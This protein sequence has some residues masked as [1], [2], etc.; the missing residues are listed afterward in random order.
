M[1]DLAILWDLARAFAKIS[2]IAIG[3]VN[4]VLPAMRHEVV[5]VLHWMSDG[6]FM[7]LFAVTQ[8]TPGPNVVIV[9]LIGW[10]MA[11]LTGLL[12]ATI[13]MLLPAC[14]LAFIVG[15]LASRVSGSAGF[16][17]AQQA[18]VPVA[19]GLIVAGG[20]DL[21]QAAHHGWLTAL[22]TAGSAAA[23]IFTKAN[24]VWALLAS[25]GVALAANYLGLAALL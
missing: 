18:L 1:I 20:L 23:I 2:L 3:G 8:I 13:A 6:T 22:M 5:D 17:L 19:I 10:Q 11:G 16:R 25:A 7:Q 15:R 12:V 4:A 21:A 24:P 9:S 14:L